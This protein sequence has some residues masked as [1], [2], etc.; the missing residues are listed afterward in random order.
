MIS[1]YVIQW[2]VGLLQGPNVKANFVAVSPI[3]GP[4]VGC[5]LYQTFLTTNEPIEYVYLKVQFPEKITG[6]K[7]G[8]MHEI[9]TAKKGRTNV[10]EYSMRRN[11]KGECYIP[12][13][14]ITPEGVQYSVNGNMLKIQHSKL[15][16]KTSI[17]AIIATTHGDSAPLEM[18]TEGAYEYTKLGQI[19]RKQLQIKNDGVIR[20]NFVLPFLLKSNH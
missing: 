2:F 4:Y 20:S 15:I 13:A 19:V 6:Y 11:D 12:E 18:Y 17:T 7:V 9:E 5:T 10:A 3:N 14:A 1:L 16:P 8:F